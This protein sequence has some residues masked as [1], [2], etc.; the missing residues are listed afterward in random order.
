[1]LL[2][3]TKSLIQNQE[4]QLQG[5]VTQIKEKLKATYKE[6]IARN[7][8][9]FQ[10]E[11]RFLRKQFYELVQRTSDMDNMMS[12]L[13]TKVIEYEY[14]LLEL[15]KNLQDRNIRSI[16]RQLNVEMPADLE[17]HL[18][19]TGCIF[20]EEFTRTAVNKYDVKGV[21]SQ[22]LGAFAT[23]LTVLPPL[24]SLFAQREDDL[25][26]GLFKNQLDLQPL[27]VAVEQQY[28][29]PQALKDK[30]HELGEVIFELQMNIGQQEI[31]MREY[32][33]LNDDCNKKVLELQGKNQLQEI[34]MEE[35]RNAFM[36]IQQGKEK[37]LKDAH[38][39][40]FAKRQEMV[41]QYN[42]LRLKFEKYKQDVAKESLV[43]EQIVK[44]W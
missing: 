6:S 9:A 27:Y 33:F 2:G 39:V 19:A 15:K 30:I 41:D 31:E 44:V 3:Q 11:E 35:M 10:N 34:Q 17:K 16:Y 12:K 4:K 20:W 43:H 40:F 42:E 13:T 22:H 21:M 29:R 18:I 38:L 7:M 5:V 8:T 28:V 14:I 32:R 26:D 23:G 37:E 1:M 24:S 36:K 25:S